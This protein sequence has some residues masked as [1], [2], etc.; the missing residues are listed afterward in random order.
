MDGWGAMFDDSGSFVGDTQGQVGATA[1]PPQTGMKRQSED[2]YGGYDYDGDGYAAKKPKQEGYDE[3]GS[4]EQQQEPGSWDEMA[5]TGESSW[6]ALKSTGDTVETKDEFANFSEI[7]S[8]DQ[9]KPS[10][11]SSGRAG[12]G[13]RGYGQGAGSWGGQQRGRGGQRGGN[14]SGGYSG[15]RGGGFNN[16]GGGFNRGGRGGGFN[17][18]GGGFN[19]RGGGFNRGGGGGRGG[20]RGGSSFGHGGGGGFGGGRSNQGLTL[21]EKF[22]KYQSFLTAETS[23]INSIQSLENAVNS[24]QLFLKCDYAVVEMPRIYNRAVYT[25]RLAISGIFLARCVGLNKKELKHE[26]Y[27]KAYKVLTTQTLAVINDLRDPG[28]DVVRVCIERELKLCGPHKFIEGGSMPVNQRVGEVIQKVAS[29]LETISVLVAGLEK[30][31]AYLKSTVNLP[32]NPISKLEQAM[33]A[34]KCGMVHLYKCDSKDENGVPLYVGEYMLEDTCIARASNVNKKSVKSETYTQALE[35][36]YSKT[37]LELIIPVVEETNQNEEEEE[38]HNEAV[39]T[40]VLQANVDGP[41]PVVKPSLIEAPIMDRLL[42]LFSTVSNSAFTKNNVTL[43]DNCLTNSG[44]TAVCVYKKVSPESKTCDLCEF[45][46]DQYLI[47]T[48]RGSSKAECEQAAY[49]SAYNMLCRTSP[50]DIV[51]NHPKLPPQ[52]T[53]D[54]LLLETEWKGVLPVTTESNADALRQHGFDPDVLTCSLGD[55]V[56]VEE[57]MWTNDRRTAAFAILQN[58]CN[59][60]GLLLKWTFQN[61]KNAATKNYKYEAKPLGKYK[62]VVYV[63]D[64]EVAQFTGF[65]KNKV[66]TVACADYLFRLVE[67]RPVLQVVK[68]DDRMVWIPLATLSME[69]ESLRKASANSPNKPPQPVNFLVQ[70]VLAR[71]KTFLPNKDGKELI[72]GPGFSD[73]DKRAICGEV[74]KQGLFYEDRFDKGDNYFVIYDKLDIRDVALRLKTQPPNTVFRKYILVPTSSL[75]KYSDINKKEL[76]HM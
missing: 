44:L 2:G 13:G 35:A 73:I 62:C 18:R 28:A 12:K 65:G 58:T 5:Y 16:R 15:G 71:V 7:T 55:M 26:V 69:A 17:N 10:D 67:H 25:G 42:N 56:L 30:L 43:I 76:Y 52:E 34:S 21:V 75:P 29:G 47:A 37:L 36:L 3:S 64:Q 57:K 61:L 60:N 72:F 54:P 38:V 14:S 33:I 74:K 27:D 51:S 40:G 20:F 4:W 49:N 31:I 53:T 24:T 68:T 22:E 45:Y 48:G 46:V 23:R 66:R 19:N 63:K 1:A 70:A 8:W 59:L 50:T 11:G 9:L 6:E 39:V 32:D 41:P